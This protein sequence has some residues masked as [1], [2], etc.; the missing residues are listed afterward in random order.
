MVVGADSKGDPCSRDKPF[1]RFVTPGD[2]RDLKNRI[3][4]FVLAL[5]ANVRDCKTLAPDV[6]Q[7]WTDFS[8]QWRGFYNEDESWLH[9]AAQ[10]DQA[11]SYECDVQRWQTLLAAQ[12]CAPDAPPISITNEGDGSGSSVGGTIKVVAIAAAVVAA[13]LALREVAK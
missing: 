9:T 4:P 3:D 2:V 8:K 10:M 1:V 11:E 12:K 6:A 7:S 5:D 13:A